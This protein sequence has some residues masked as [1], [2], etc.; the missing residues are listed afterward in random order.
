M[1][2]E[3][4]A[5]PLEIEFG[6]SSVAENPRLLISRKSNFHP[7]SV[8][9]E[10]KNEKI[11]KIREESLYNNKQKAPNFWMRV[12]HFTQDKSSICFRRFSAHT[13][14]PTSTLSLSRSFSRNLEQSNRFPAW[15]LDPDPGEVVE[16]QQKIKCQQIPLTVSP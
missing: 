11:T 6:V 3:E 2:D 14:N 16:Y 12:T 1:Y 13:N 5:Q 10:Q 7:D 9:I 8:K 4:Q 15:D